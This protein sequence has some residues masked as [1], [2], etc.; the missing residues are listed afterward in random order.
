[1]TYKV[2]TT[3]K[4]AFSL[5]ELLVS[6]VILSLMMV[7]LYKSYS[8]LNISNDIYK[9]KSVTIKTLELKKKTIYLDLLM[10]MPNSLIHLDKDT[11]EDIISFQTTNSIHKRFNPYITYVLKDSRLYRLESLKKIKIYPFDFDIDAVIDDLGEVNRFK[12]YKSDSK[13]DEIYLI[14]VEFKD[15]SDILLKTKVLSQ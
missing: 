4:R 2:S 14:N 9:N 15:G 10:A 11:K 8:S 12:V 7:A 1:M 13:D 6:I 5:I 3:S